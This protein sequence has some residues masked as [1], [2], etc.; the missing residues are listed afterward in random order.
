MAWLLVETQS[1]RQC[2]NR[3]LR[4]KV[5]TCTFSAVDAT[6]AAYLVLSVVILAFMLVLACN[7]AV[8]LSSVAGK[9]MKKM[10][11]DIGLFVV[12]PIVLLGGLMVWMFAATTPSCTNGITQ[13]VISPDDRFKA[14]VFVTSCNTAPGFSSHISILA[15]DGILPDGPGNLFATEGHPEQLGFTL[16]WQS[17]DKDRLQL[18]IASQQR[19]AVLHADPVWSVN[20]NIT[21]TY[22]L[23]TLPG[24]PA[25]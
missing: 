21:A 10:V 19:G 5:L 4:C 8:L 11:R 20:S 13:Q 12:A 9:R 3:A 17:I 15:K 2:S 16:Q 22:Q 24:K 18:N 25:H 1:P 14:V 6:K 23:G 7:G